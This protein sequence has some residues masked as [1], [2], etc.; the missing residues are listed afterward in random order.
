MDKL[1]E[2]LIAFL[3]GELPPEERARVER[4]AGESR[5]IRAELDWL[6]AAYVDIEAVERG[7]RPRA[8]DIDIVDSVMHAVRKATTP[9]EVVLIESARSRRIGWLPALAAAA[10]ILVTIG[11]VLFSGQEQSNSVQPG[12]GGKKLAQ[13][14]AV[15]PAKLPTELAKIKER[16]DK[17]R[18]GLGHTPEDDV[19]R[20]ELTQGPRIELPGG[21]SDVVA[22][23]RDA[24]MSGASMDKLLQWARLSK[25]DALDI[26]ESDNASPEVMLGAAHSLSGDDQ[27]RVLLTAVGKL[28][29]DPGS[30]LQLARAYLDDPA[31]EPGAA[32][33][34]Q[35]RAAAQLSDVKNIDPDNAL[36]YYFEAK[37]QLD[38]GDTAA[39]LATLQ[40]AGTLGK[41]SAYSLESALAEAEALKA[42]GMEPEAARMVA[43]LT[44]G[45]DENN[46]LCQL[47]GDLLGYGQGFLSE[48]DSA[49]A[50]AI[51]KAVE[52][53]GR[54]VEEGAAFSQEQLAGMD[55]QIQ[56]LGGLGQLYTIV[57]SADGVASV[58]EAANALT[59]KVEDVA[60]FFAALDELFLKPMTTG[61]WNMVSGIIL[62]SGDI[63]LFSNQ[64]VASAAPPPSSP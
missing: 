64:D 44:A 10:A 5:A 63:S 16:L 59:I 11:Y 29:E 52:E 43:S 61:F 19:K 24:A 3:E 55:I 4:E 49:T 56:A 25:E 42:A 28:Q 1:H 50:E 2:E 6:R 9:A 54:Q 51:F 21:V 40:A 22:A 33:E 27:R 20:L 13:P 57:E 47:A 38:A 62:G 14:H 31:A 7:A 30:R 60:G 26:A 46:F 23:R 8:A 18:N 17:Q 45:I 37:A 35:A 34:N 15:H 48:N 41:A 53:F 12:S 36:P 32:A 58:T 39:A